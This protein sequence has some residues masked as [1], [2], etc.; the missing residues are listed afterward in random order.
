M[1][2]AGTD[3]ISLHFDGD[4]ALQEFQIH[5]HP[6][7]GLFTR[8]YPFDAFQRASADLY[9]LAGAQERCV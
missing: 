7:L 6:A 4:S 8:Q 5:H 2:G 3:Q 1:L 9:S